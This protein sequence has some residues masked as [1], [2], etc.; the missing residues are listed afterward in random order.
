MDMKRFIWRIDYLFTRKRRER[1]QRVFE[2]A[3][4]AA[5]QRL[6]DWSSRGSAAVS[7]FLAVTP[8]VRAKTDE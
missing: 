4:R 8:T 5:Q 7:P 3:Q 1:E 2:G 6:E